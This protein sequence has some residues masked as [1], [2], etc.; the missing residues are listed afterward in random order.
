[1]FLLLWSNCMA[2]TQGFQKI[3]GTGFVTYGASNVIETSNSGFAVLRYAYGADPLT[4]LRTD[5]LGNKLWSIALHSQ[6]W[7]FIQTKDKGFLLEG[8]DPG[9]YLVHM[10]KTDS[11]GQPQWSKT[12]YPATQ[13]GGA[14]KIIELNDGYAVC[15]DEPFVLM[16]LDFSGNIVWMTKEGYSLFPEYT[17]NDFVQLKSDSCFYI[18]NDKDRFFATPSLDRAITKINKNGRVLW[19]KILHI[20]VPAIAD[21]S[22]ARIQEDHKGKL[23]ITVFDT[24][25]HY[26]YLITLDS[27]AVETRC[28]R[29]GSTATNLNLLNS[30]WA[31][32]KDGPENSLYRVTTITNQNIQD[33]II[34]VSKYDS[35]GNGVWSRKIGGAKN[36]IPQSITQTKDGGMIIAG[37]TN[38]FHLS[39]LYDLYLV[40]MNQAGRIG[41]SG[42]TLPVD[43]GSPVSGLVTTSNVTD[44]I[45]SVPYSDSTS[46]SNINPL[47]LTEPAFDAC[48]CHPP[49]AAFWGDFPTY[50]AV[51][52]DSSL[53]ETHWYWSFGDGTIDSVHLNPIHYYSDTTLSYNVCLVI[54]NSCGKD[55]VCHLL[56]HRTSPA[57]IKNIA[58]PF[59]I[60][61]FPNPTQGIIYITLPLNNP[62]AVMKMEVFDVYGRIVKADFQP[63]KDQYKMDLSGFPDGIYFLKLVYNDKLVVQ[64]IVLQH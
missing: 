39:N 37:Q 18:L 40:R 2:Q 5:S 33:N 1:M 63:L 24:A 29:F 45:Q 22:F 14:S 6:Y 36:Q 58:S 20:Q 54:T 61:V 50:Y 15:F 56:Q 17:T 13:N 7:N 34:V 30:A 28:L 44:P 31:V 21:Q 26:S 57:G 48:I 12:Y 19:T 55:S 52:N 25:L 43:S 9:F 11:L 51:F 64:K 38:S 8:T 35:L 32:S 49:I 27:A 46:N 47:S 3:F 59:S 23:N 10:T 16:K 4:L 53:W 42:D 41:C 60:P 62:G